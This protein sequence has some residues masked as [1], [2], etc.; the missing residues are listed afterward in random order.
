MKNFQT[1]LVSIK[2]PLISGHSFPIK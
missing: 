2:N 1:Y